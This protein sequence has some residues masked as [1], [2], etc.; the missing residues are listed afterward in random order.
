MPVTGRRALRMDPLLAAHAG[1]IAIA[2][3]ALLGSGAAP[4]TLGR[5]SWLLSATFEAGAF[6]FAR[7]AARLLPRRDPARRFWQVFSWAAL[8]IAAG[9]ASQ[10]LLTARR[11]ADASLLFG[12][13]V[14]LALLAVAATAI[15]VTMCTYPL[16]LH[17]VR[18]RWCF[19]LD[20][21]TVLVSAAAFGWYFADPAVGLMG[22][23]TSPGILI[24]GVFA[25]AKLLLSGEP[26]FSTSAGLIGVTAAAV[27]GISG[28]L[29]PALFADGHPG[30]FYAGSMLGDALIMASARV[31]SRQIGA[32]PN[33]L[34]ETPRRP[35]SVL[36]YVAVAAAYGLLA[37]ALISHG[38]DSRSWLVLGAAGTATGLA[39]LRQLTSLA[40][41]ERLLRELRQSERGLRTALHERD[42]LAVQLRELAYRDSLTGLANRALFTDRFAAALTRARRHRTDLVVLLLDLDRFKPINDEYGHAA[43]DT[44]LREV[45]TRLRTCLR[46]HDTVARLGGDE[47]GI[48]LEPPLP[49]DLDAVVRRLEAVVRAPIEF[50]EVRITVGT[51]I[52]SAACVA[53]DGEIDDL[54]HIADL[55]MYGAKRLGRPA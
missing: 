46:E 32:N 13:P 33:I 30:W 52:G 26:P 20:M 3:A 39:V 12:G 50:G 36:P 53:G 2:L 8:V 43:G 51:S 1:V 7:R 55:A 34:R 41:N 35:Y 21:A 42:E 44:V 28:G 18:E 23:L 27:G 11:G 37:A 40:D 14:L 31:Q 6:V 45:A 48:L 25:A 22:I 9:Y 54:L 10:L 15:I 47:F 29:G 17:S 5:I 24:V 19:L 49:A 16:R 38:V 4:L